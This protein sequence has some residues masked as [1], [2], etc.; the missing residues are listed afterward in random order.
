LPQATCQACAAETSAVEGRCAGQLFRPAR[1][2]LRLPQKNRKT[3]VKRGPETFDAT[4]DG[5]PVQLL[6]EDFPALLVSFEF[7]PPGIIMRQPKTELFA[8]RVVIGRLPTFAD[9]LG[10]LVAKH[11]VQD[12][13]SLGN[14]GDGT[15][16]DRMLAKIGHGYAVAELGLRSFRPFLTDIILNRPPMYIG[17]YVGGLFGHMPKGD[18]LHL[19]TLSNF[20]GRNLIVVEIQ[21]FAEREMPVFVVVAGERI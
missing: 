4:I 10:R 15:D 8:G 5:K 2:E 12:G 14:Q 7:D 9:R 17:H 11:S 3:K 16:L 21:L 20:W 6:Q 19:I 13:I 18:D 1:R